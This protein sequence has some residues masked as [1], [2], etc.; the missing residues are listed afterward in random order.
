MHSRPL[1]RHQGTKIISIN[2][3]GSDELCLFLRTA[4]GGF[5][6]SC[7]S[8]PSIEHGI[9]HPLDPFACFDTPDALTKKRVVLGLSM[10]NECD[11]GEPDHLVV[12]RLGRRTAA[13]AA[14]V[15]EAGVLGDAR[16][17]ACG[18]CG[19]QDADVGCEIRDVDDVEFR[20]SCPIPHTALTADCGISASQLIAFTAALT[21]VGIS[22]TGGS[23]R[24][25]CIRVDQQPQFHEPAWPPLPL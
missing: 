3:N 13:D 16:L 6:V 11:D 4:Q 25:Q 2:T 12:E 20:S 10:T 9:N 8:A 22:E 5:A 18:C 24:L 17:D 7:C 15:L 19:I 1:W 23:R 21:R 14:A